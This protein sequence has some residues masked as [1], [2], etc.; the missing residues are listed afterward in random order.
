MQESTK[1]QKSQNSSLHRPAAESDQTNINA[2]SEKHLVLPKTHD[3]SETYKFI[4]TENDIKQNNDDVSTTS[5]PNTEDQTE[6]GESPT[7]NIGDEYDLSSGQDYQ[8]NV[9]SYQT[10]NQKRYLYTVWG[11]WSACT[12][13][14]GQR[15]YAFR[16]RYCI[17]TVTGEIKKHCQRPTI[18]AKKCAL[19]PCP[20]EFSAR[21]TQNSP[22]H[23]IMENLGAVA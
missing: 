4:G 13:T 16:K 2:T 11:S 10:A 17:N 6:D 1:M 5:R 12:R 14:C 18:L 22:I 8:N 21:N 7:E 9:A 20:G 3:D 23:K 19:S 15:A